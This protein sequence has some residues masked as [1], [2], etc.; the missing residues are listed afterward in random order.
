MNKENLKQ[1]WL[2]GLLCFVVSVTTAILT[3]NSIPL[4]SIAQES[5]SGNPATPPAADKPTAD[6]GTKSMAGVLVPHDFVGIANKVKPTVVNISTSHTMK[7]KEFRGFRGSEEFK[8]FF[9]E[10]FFNRFFGGN[11]PKQFKQRSLGSGFII[12]K[13]GYIVSNH[14]VVKDADEIKVKL[15][16]DSEYTAKVVGKDP[17][18]DIVLLKIDAKK[19]L[20]V[21]EFGDSDAVQVGEWVIAV[22][23]PFGL[24]YTVTAGIISAKGRVIGAG[25]YDDF[26]QTDAS[27]NPGNSGGPLVNMEGKI[28]GINTAIMASGQGIGFAIPINE[29]KHIIEDLKTKGKVTRGWLGLM[30]QEVTP[31]LAE[32]FNLAEHKGALVANVVPDS[33]ADKAG[34]KR[35]DVVIEF[36]GKKINEYSDLPKLAARAEPG[37]SVEVKVNRDG[38]EQTFKVNIGEFPEE[39]AEA[40]TTQEGNTIEEEKLGMAVQELTPELAEGLNLP[41]DEKGV[42]V[43]EVEEGG[44]AA[45]AGI[46]RGDIIKEINRVEVKDLK[47]YQ[48]ALKSSK[49]NMILL[50]VKRGEN[51]IYRVIKLDEGMKEGTKQEKK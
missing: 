41:K 15:A 50:L 20:P 5:K 25:P 4:L 46:R 44:P 28:I 48:E 39:V 37:R 26:L 35:G 47:G 40:A 42:L 21:L 24:N 13:Q 18:T 1:I 6:T 38:K 17:K 19:D 22:G 3:V 16:D 31:E 8:D 30:I 32:S 33:P 10:D 2:I 27:I 34:I 12:D 51:S 11:P 9:G 45:E 7:R 23:N 49:D 43:S 36:D 29:A 14:H